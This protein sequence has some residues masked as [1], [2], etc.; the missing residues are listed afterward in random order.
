MNNQS[1]EMLLENLQAI[2]THVGNIINYRNR[3]NYLNTQF[4]Q[5]RELLKNTD[6]VGDSSKRALICLIVNV[7]LLSVSFVVTMY[8]RSS[9]NFLN[10]LSIQIGF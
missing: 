4:Y 1:P 8:V 10:I 6:T 3:I 2:R 9:V 7:W 5:K